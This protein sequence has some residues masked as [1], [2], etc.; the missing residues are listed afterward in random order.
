[1]HI[2]ILVTNAGKE[3]FE[4]EY[5]SWDLKE[6]SDISRPAELN[7]KC[8]RTIPINRY[9]HIIAKEDNKYFFRGYIR[10]GK[11]KNLK[12]RELKCKGEEDLLLRRF[13]PRIA[14]QANT[15]RLDHV[16]QS[17][18]PN[19]IADEYGILNNVGL[20]FSASSKIPYYGNVVTGSN[21]I[22]FDWWALT[23][24]WIYKLSGLGLNS[25]LGSANIYAG[26]YLLN[27]MSSYAHLLADN[28]SCW[29]DENDL[30]V[31]FDDDSLIN[32]GFGAKYPMFAEYA[33]DTNI[34]AGQI[35][36]GDTLL[37]GNL[38]LN[39]ER[40]LDILKDVAEFYGLNPHFR[41]ERNYSYLDCL[42]SPVVN[43]FTITED[44]I[45]DVSQQSAD[46]QRVHALIGLGYGSR[47]VQH[48]YAP[49]DHS[50]Q[51][52]WL[53]DTIDVDEGFIDALGNVRPYVNAEYSYRYYDDLFTVTPA[54][55]WKSRPEIDDKI[56]LILNGE[57]DRLLEVVSRKL[58]HEGEFEFE[59]GNRK[60]D[61][62]DAFN[63]KDSLDR[64][65]QSEYLV[66][67]GKSISASS[68]ASV[69]GDL[70]HGSCTGASFSVTIPADVYESDW[71]HRVTVDIGIDTDQSPIACMVFVQINGGENIYSQMP[72]YLLGDQITGLDITRYCNY[73]SAS[74]IAIWVVKKGE[75]SGASCSAHPTMDINITVKSWKRTIL[76][77]NIKRGLNKQK[78]TYATWKKLKGNVYKWVRA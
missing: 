44:Q 28:Y 62:M 52:I 17:D 27:R 70:T 73:G 50:W 33:Y 39:F 8:S 37:T 5:D 57:P 48:V 24:D 13:A 76:G 67:F 2:E 20:L 18:P 61:I 1:M 45:K 12:T 43:E 11:L 42:D 55:D 58:N 41:R 68:T 47:D 40:M 53:E 59:L 23:T 29:S 19:Q 26:G 74:T 14:Y 69:M 32:C 31:R 78:V 9:A 65:Y 38:Q 10:Q 35:D 25:R 64:V 54:P 72:F 4:I 21:P 30:W 3:P 77:S 6:Y 75:W 51:G 7:I 71:S 22:E 34:R 49:S 46:D 16:F 56:N 66:E 63:S 15:I 36:L 60:S